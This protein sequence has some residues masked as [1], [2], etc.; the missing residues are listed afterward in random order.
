MLISKSYGVADASDS[1]LALAR[2]EAHYIFNGCFLPKTTAQQGYLLAHME[3]LGHLPATIIQGRYDMICPAGTAYDLARAWPNADLK[4]IPAAGHSA[5]EE[6]IRRAL[7][8][9]T[10][11]MAVRILRG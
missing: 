2:L 11:D 10:D 1:T 4:I 5:L 8:A 7:V 9:A 3:R 6:G